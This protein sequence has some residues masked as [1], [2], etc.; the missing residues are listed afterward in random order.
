MAEQAESE[1]PL[2]PAMRSWKLITTIIILVLFPP[3][4]Y[5]PM[6]FINLQWVAPRADAERAHCASLLCPAAASWSRLGFLLV[7]APSFLAAG[8]AIL[9]GARGFFR[10]LRHP[11]SPGNRAWFLALMVGGLVWASLFGPFL[12]FGLLLAGVPL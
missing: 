1:T 6:Y 9:W 2:L 7:F 12:L 3:L 8:A 5:L 11:T 10:E 4:L